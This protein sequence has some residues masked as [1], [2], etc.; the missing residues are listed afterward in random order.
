MYVITNF[1]KEG[2][3]YKL[4][5][6]QLQ[7]LLNL[8]G[9]ELIVDGDFGRKTTN[10]VKSF[11]E[12]EQLHVDGKVGER[13]WF[14]LYK[15][16]LIKAIELQDRSSEYEELS[17]GSLNQSLVLW[18]QSILYLCDNQTLT[19][20]VYDELL[21]N[22]VRLF[23]TLKGCDETACIS[24]DDWKILFDSIK[25]EIEEIVT[26]FLTDDVIIQKAKENNVSPA[27]VKAVIKVESRGRGFQRDKRLIILFEG[28]IFW[29]QLKD[30]GINPHD[31]VINNED[32]LFPSPNYAYYGENQYLRLE[33][34]QEI[35]NDAALKS[36]SWGM[37]QIMGFN[38]QS[39]GFDTVEKMIDSFNINEEH[40]LD[41]FFTFLKNEDILK[42]LQA[43][44]WDKFAYRYNGK[45]YKRNQYDLKL[46]NAYDGSTLT[47]DIG[48]KIDEETLTTLYSKELEK[49]FLEF[50]EFDKER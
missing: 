7:A 27:A 38:H 32:I 1:I 20:R 37:F 15:S 43:K 49:A 8:L 9:E 6:N 12:K 47:K 5:I 46:Q 50:T 10:A 3:P 16:S 13:S 34:A 23:Q 35:N 17:F 19:N 45:K 22:R 26:L 29:Y 36:T 2:H 21:E 42:H 14:K 28:H 30:S 25:K 40:Q 48:E 39:A 18:L 11:Q 44:D 24:T 4:A 41:A 33:K 31:F